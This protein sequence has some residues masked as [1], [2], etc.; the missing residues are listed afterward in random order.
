MGFHP[1]PVVV[2]NTI[3]LLFFLPGSPIFNQPA[4]PAQPQP[5]LTRAQEHSLPAM[6]SVYHP[7]L[8]MSRVPSNI[9]GLDT[10]L[11]HFIAYALL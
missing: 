9:I 3:V 1:A 7:S 11:L 5:P 2:S 6:W 10:K 4:K 8:H